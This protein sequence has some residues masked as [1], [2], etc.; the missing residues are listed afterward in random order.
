MLRSSRKVRDKRVY[1]SENLKKT[2][3]TVLKV[4]FE[5]LAQGSEINIRLYKLS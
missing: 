2:A 5:T 3:Q 4:C 1:G